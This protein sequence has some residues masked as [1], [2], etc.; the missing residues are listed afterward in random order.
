[1]CIRDRLQGD[2]VDKRHRRL[3]GQKPVAHVFPRDKKPCRGRPY[4]DAS[5]GAH[6]RSVA[7]NSGIRESVG[8]RGGGGVRR[9]LISM[10]F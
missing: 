7:E 5:D 1:M 10:R 6:A 9:N 4:S 3:A 8:F 2:N